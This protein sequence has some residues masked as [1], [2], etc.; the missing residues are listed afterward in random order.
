M[1]PDINGKDLI[2]NIKSNTEFSSSYIILFSS[3]ETSPGNNSSGM[4][5]GADEYI[6]RPVNNRELVARVEA[7][8][9]II[10]AERALKACIDSPNDMIILAID[11]QY[12]YLAFNTYH[13][14]VMLKAYGTNVKTGMNLIECMKGDEDIAKAKENY[15]RALDGES[16]ITIEEFGE[17]DRQYYETRYNPIFNIESE[18]IGATAFSF[19]VTERVKLQEK[20]KENERLLKE[21]QT[22][23]GLGTYV[24]D[25]TTGLWDSSEILD[26]IFGIDKNYVRSFEGWI[27]IIDPKLQDTMSHYV[28]N[29]VV[30]QK[31]RFDKEYRIIRKSDGEKRWV[32][33]LGEL[34][35]DDYNIPIKLIGTISD[36]TD[37]KLAEEAL[38]ESESLYKKMVENSP[39]GMHFYELNNDGDL[40]FIAANKA[41]DTILNTDSSRFI[42]KTI[43]E[44]FPPLVN[45]EVPQ[46]YADA[47][48]NGINWSTEQITYS[49]E[50]V[51]GAFEV[52]VFQ[53]NPRKMVAVFSDITKRK[54][55]EVTLKKSEEKYRLLAENISDVIWILDPET[56][57]FLYVSPSVERLRGHTAEEILSQEI[58]ASI[59]EDTV[60]DVINTTRNRA[61]AFLSGEESPGKYYTDEI[62]QPHKGGSA[63]V[64]EVITSYYINQENGRVEVLGVT[65][66]ITDRKLAEEQVKKLNIELEQRVNERTAQLEDANKE[67][68][69]FAYSV[70][71][72][73]RAPLRAIE[74][75]SKFLLENSGPKLNS[76]GKRLLDMIRIN[77]Q[78]MDHL[79]VDILALSRVSRSELKISGIDMTSMAV[80]MLNEVASDEIQ[81]RIDILIDTLPEVK[82]D[83]TYLKLVW[84]N[85][86]SNAI[87]FS[88]HKKKP[89]IEIRGYS[90]NDCNIYFVKDNGV[91]FDPRYADKLFG[92]FQRLHKSDEFEG[93]GVGLA[94]VQRII[95]RHGGKVWA[96]G[97]VGKGAT[98]YFS[99]PG[100]NK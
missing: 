90:E 17:F 92:V 79:I 98:F 20:L 53:T 15:G 13:R 3:L 64:T 48:K 44:A 93:T 85:I 65:R 31:K 62:R 57:R 37:R 81:K 50:Y 91:G 58:S 100:K 82:G 32:H 6:I 74:G 46:R 56:M 87:K 97:K 27:K 47:A 22:V 51:T 61:K 76:E 25:L 29:E 40:I 69:A 52:K 83:P 26:E 84:I 94:I 38:K 70:S 49:D 30:G 99:L 5:E 23:A 1:L 75:F 41:S 34:Q 71:H 96:E 16:H 72:D 24:W 35:S 80:S 60:D 36:I 78:K 73:L 95:H 33:G 8:R 67:L 19:N 54:L 2:K 7:A 68:Q 10:T 66:D 42:G 14:N 89:K 43:Q 55:A 18:I 88:S 39:L 12:N 77:T 9:R 59:M 28:T 4:E 63:I 11:T 86:F 45:T 21:S